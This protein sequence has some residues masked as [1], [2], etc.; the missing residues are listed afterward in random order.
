[1]YLVCIITHGTKSL[2]LLH[3][4]ELLDKHKHREINSMIRTLTILNIK[5]LFCVVCADFWPSYI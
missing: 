1:M 5:C 4:T 3:L 2:F